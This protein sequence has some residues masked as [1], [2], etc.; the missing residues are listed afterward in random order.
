LVRCKEC[1]RF[2]PSELGSAADRSPCP[3]C[4]GTALIIG[5][6]AHLTGEG[7]L[8]ALPTL[9]PGDQ[10]QGW[11][12][13]WQDI[14]TEAAN[15]VQPLTTPMTGRAIQAARQRLLDFY[16]T[17]YHLKDDL[18]RSSAVTGVPKQVVENAVTNDPDLALL[19]DLANLRKHGKL[20]RVRSGHTPREVSRAGTALPGAPSPGWR[21][22]L[23]IVHNG[24][25]LDGL[26][27]A[28]RSVT[29]WRRTLH[30]WNL[31]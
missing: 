22:S 1:G 20:N 4:Q 15:L 26:D 30:G 28:Q 14:E 13:R 17:A 6:S 27:L 10:G 23:V 31:I 16:V 12:R 11:D 7:T 25:M 18:I 29:A 19:A 2:R 9:L 3:H 8:T 24:A 5:A 21:L